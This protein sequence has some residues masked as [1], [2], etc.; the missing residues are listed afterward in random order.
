MTVGVLG[1][2]DDFDRSI[3]LIMKARKNSVVDLIKKG[4]GVFVCYYK[5][6]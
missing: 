2:P 6:C 1:M 5:L 4:V 3:S